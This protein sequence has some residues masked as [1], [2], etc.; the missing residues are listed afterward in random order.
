MNRLSSFKLSLLTATAA[1][2]SVLGSVAACGGISDPSRSDGTIATVAG[3]LSGAALPAKTRVAIVWR[4]D[5]ATHYAVGADVAVVDGK[6]AFDLAAPQQAYLVPTQADDFGD[7]AG[8]QNTYEDDA[9]PQAAPSTPP[10]TG[11]PAASSAKEAF[12]AN[13]TPRDGVGGQISNGLAVGFAGF[14]VYV[15]TND[16]GKLDLAGELAA[17][18]DEIIG[19]NSSLTLTYLQGAGATDLETLRDKVNAL[20]AAGYN[21]L[22][23]EGGRWMPLT[24]VDLKLN[25]AARLSSFVCSAPSTDGDSAQNAPSDSAT[26]GS[27][28]DAKAYPI[29]TN[30]DG[31]PNYDALGPYISCSDDGRSFISTGP[32]TNGTPAGAGLCAPLATEE[33]CPPGVPVSLAAG[34][35]FPAGWPCPV[36]VEG[37]LDGGAAPDSGN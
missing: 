5:A 36:G 7:G 2:I 27:V 14:V 32:C 1:S 12:A 6:F 18:T 37:G 16:N 13:V 9:P 31:S 4:A 24:S 20:P 17:S 21:L 30:P 19:G 15:D 33:S 3:A 29:G 8:A 28:P 34:E 10:S 35:P 25:G 23:S 26:P 11:T 22:W